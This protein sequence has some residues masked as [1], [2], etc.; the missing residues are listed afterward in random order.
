MRKVLFYRYSEFEICIRWLNPVAL[1]AV[2]LEKLLELGLGHA[3]MR[4]FK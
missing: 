3:V 2:F 4:C 1:L